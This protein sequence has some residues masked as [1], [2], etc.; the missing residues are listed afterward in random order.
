MQLSMVRILCDTLP[1][2]YLYA[3]E[4]P[5]SA[6]ISEL[7][8]HPAAPM[9]TNTLTSDNHYFEILPKTV[10]FKRKRAT[11]SPRIYLSPVAHN[12]LL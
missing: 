12:I 3:H 5:T 11:E 10:R 1:V 9:S 8:R 7:L 2:R 4:A 6:H